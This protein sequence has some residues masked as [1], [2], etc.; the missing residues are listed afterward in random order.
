MHAFTYTGVAGVP[1]HW[2]Y[3]DRYAYRDDRW[4]YGPPDKGWPYLA[5]ARI[6]ML[7]DPGE[8][9][10]PVSVGCFG[11]FAVYKREY[12]RQ[13]DQ[14]YSGHDKKGRVDC[15]HI[16]FSQCLLSKGGKLWMNPSSWIR[17]P[18]TM[19]AP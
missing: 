6:K 18:V 8:E 11:G 16:A 13:C 7:Y 19:Y 14:A 10:V 4:P 3:W 17:Y 15:E 9:W 1:P 2:Y 5:D 12:V